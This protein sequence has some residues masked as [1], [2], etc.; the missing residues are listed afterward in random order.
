[1]TSLSFSTAQYD[2]P[3][4][5]EQ[6]LTVQMLPEN[7][8]DGISWMSSDESIAVVDPFR[9]I[10]QGHNAKYLKMPKNSAFS[11][12]PTIHIFSYF[13]YPAYRFQSDG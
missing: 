13:S 11:S 5:A 12:T 10:C 6:R 4:G 9:T 1:M 8:T 3:I 7:T 2:L